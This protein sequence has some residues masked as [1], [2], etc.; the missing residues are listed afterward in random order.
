MMK[1]ITSYRAHRTHK[2]RQHQALLR[3]LAYLNDPC[4]FIFPVTEGE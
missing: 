4:S 1:L 3:A 2:K